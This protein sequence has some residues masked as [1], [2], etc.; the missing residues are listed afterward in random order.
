[1]YIALKFFDAFDM[2]DRQLYGPSTNKGIGSEV[3]VYNYF[4]SADLV[5][6][7]K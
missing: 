3:V 1:M 2:N 4:L 6:F 7:A 5:V